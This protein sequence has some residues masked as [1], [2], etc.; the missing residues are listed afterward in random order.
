MAYYRPKQKA[1]NGLWYPNGVTVGKPVTVDEVAQLLSRM[2]TVNVADVYA[3]LVNLGQAMGHYMAHGR[4][5]K[6]KG[7][8]TFYY[9]PSCK[10]NGVA[11]RDEV[12][13]AQI[14]GTHVRFIPEVRRGTDG[15]VVAHSFMG[16]SVEWF[17]LREDRADGVSL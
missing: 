14:K 9:T 3:V 7:V 8:G 4:T 1:I 2:S 11:T 15:R 17:E 12:S 10:G 13:A 16:R 5:V 6:L